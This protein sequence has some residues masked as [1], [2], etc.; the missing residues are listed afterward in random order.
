MRYIWTAMVDFNGIFVLPFV[1]IYDRSLYRI[2]AVFPCAG[3]PH[4]TTL[5]LFILI[6]GDKQWINV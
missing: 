4:S 6:A 2:L 5:L 1:T 3:R